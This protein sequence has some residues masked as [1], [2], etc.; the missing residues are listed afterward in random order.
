MEHC[1]VSVQAAI[2][3]ED[4]LFI[5]LQS[6]EYDSEKYHSSLKYLGQG[7]E[8]TGKENQIKCVHTS[9]RVSLFKIELSLR[10]R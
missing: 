6:P 10:Q 1:N 8:E 3:H 5:F 9:S 4:L 7:V 2:M